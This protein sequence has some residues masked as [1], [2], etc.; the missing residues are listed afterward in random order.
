MKALILSAGFGSRLGA[1]TKET[2][3]ALVR[4]GDRAII[5]HNIRKLLEIGVKE[6]LINTHYLA[7]QIEEFLSDQA[8]PAEVS[9]VYE[10]ELLGTAGTLKRNI[11][12]FGIGDFLVMHGDNYFTS[13][14]KSLVGAHTRRS[15]GTEMTM[16][17]FETK[18]PEFCGTVVTDSA[19]VVR[20]FQEKIKNSRSFKANAAIYI[21]SHLAKQQIFSLSV[22]ESDISLHLIPKMLGKIQSHPLPGDFIDIGTPL[23]LIQATNSYMPN[24]LDLNSQ[25]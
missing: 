14:L 1:L 13:D 5:D 7:E 3:K 2:P 21:F 17:T 8:Y 22:E 24:Q 15:T 25:G 12:F 20:E 10:P 23:G 18:H 11:D 9:T 4:V 6:I 16:A 19:G